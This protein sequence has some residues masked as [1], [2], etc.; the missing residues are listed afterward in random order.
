[1]ILIA[2]HVAAL[3]CFHYLPSKQGTAA[4]YILSRFQYS[5]KNDQQDVTV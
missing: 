1:L 2:M 4:V 3:A 5:Y